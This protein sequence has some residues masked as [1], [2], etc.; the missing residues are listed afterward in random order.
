MYRK[1]VFLLATVLLL[2]LFTPSITSMAAGSNCPDGF[3]LVMHMDHE[4]HE[5]Q[6]VGI[7]ADLNGDGSICMMPVT[8]GGT[9]HVHVDN[10]VP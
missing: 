8:P 6:H 1:L 10:N 5:H 4:D 7:S 3:I 9:I 2:T